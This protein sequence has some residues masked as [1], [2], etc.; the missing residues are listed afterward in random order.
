MTKK[1]ITLTITISD[2]SESFQTVQLNTDASAPIIVQGVEDSS[3]P[4][5]TSVETSQ[6]SLPSSSPPVLS[7]VLSPNLRFLDVNGEWFSLMGYNSGE[8]FSLTFL[9]VVRTEDQPKILS[10]LGN[11]ALGKEVQDLEFDLQ[12]K[13]GKLI[14]VKANLQPE[15]ISGRLS[16]IHVFLT[17]LKQEGEVISG[18][19]IS[20]M[21]LVASKID[22]PIVITDADGAIEL[23][24]ESFTRLT[25]FSIAEVKGR[26]LAYVLQGPGSDPETARRIHQKLR[27]LQTFT[28][29]VLIYQNNK[30]Y[31]LT[32][33]ISPIFNE[34]GEVEKY[35][36]IETD[37]NT[38]KELEIQLRRSE[39]RF[40][41]FL[42]Y[43]PIGAAILNS[44]GKFELL[45]PA[46]CKAV[47]KSS[48]SLLNQPLSALLGNI[49]KNPFLASWQNLLSSVEPHKTKWL[50][51]PENKNVAVSIHRIVGKDNLPRLLIFIENTQPTP[52]TSTPSL[53]ELNFLNALS[54]PAWALDNKGQVR[55]ANSALAN[56]LGY[57]ISEILNKPYHSFIE[58]SSL[59]LQ[60]ER[61]RAAFREES[62]VPQVVSLKTK[63][64]NT[65]SLRADSLLW[66]VSTNEKLL[67]TFWQSDSLPIAKSIENLQTQQDLLQNL[68][69]SQQQVHALRKSVLVVELTPEGIITYANENF[70]EL[71]G[72]TLE[73]LK[74]KP[75]NLLLFPEDAASQEYILFWKKLQGGSFVRG[76]FRRKTKTGKAIWINGAY[77]PII[78]S[79]GNI[80]KILKIATDVTEKN[81]LTRQMQDY[82]EELKA[83]EEELRQNAEE[84]QAINNQMALVQLQLQNQVNALNNSAIV[85][86]TDLQG[87]IIF[88]NDMFTE[89]SKYSKEELLGKN[90]RILKSGHQPQEIFIDL[91]RTISSGKVWKGIIKNRAKDGSYYW[92]ATTIT[93]KLGPDGKPEKYIAIRFDITR[94]K[95]QEIELQNYIEQLKTQEEEIRQNAEELQAINTQLSAAQLHLRNQITALNNSAIV[96]E[97]DLQGNITFV[98]EMFTQ[99]SKYS[100]Q[101]LLGQNHRILK[102][103][104][105]PQ[106]IFIDLWR[107]ISSGKVWK[108]IIKNRAKD[109]SYYWVATTITP[110]L[111]ADGKPTKYIG[112][113]FDITRQKEQENQ[114]E[115]YIFQL[116]SQEEELR[117]NA[118]ELLAIQETLQQ[119]NAELK[120]RMNAIDR[121]NIVIEFDRT[122]HILKLNE[123]AQKLLKRN[124]N[125]CIGMHHSILLFR[126][127]L[128][129]LDYQTFWQRLQG[130]VVISGEFKLKDRENNAVWISGSYAPLMDK[131]NE[132]Y[133]IL[134]IANDTTERNL[135]AKQLEEYLEE[136]RAQ[137]EELRQNAAELESI[138]RE[139]K[140][141]QI[142]LKGQINALN[143]AAI[144]SETDLEGNITFANEM[145]CKVSQYSVEELIGKNHRILKSGLQPQELFEDLWRTISQGKVWKGVIINK[146]KDG[147]FY[148][149]ASTITPEIGED[150]KP[151]KYISVRFEITTQKQQ[152]EQ[153]QQ[154]VDELKAQEEELR[155]NA[156]EMRSIQEALQQANAELDNRMAA[157]DSSSIVLELETNSGRI[158]RSNLNAIQCLGYTEEEFK[159]LT[160]TH[161]LRNNQSITKFNAAWPKLLA[162]I[163]VRE[164]FECSSKNRESKWVSAT[165]SPILNRLK[166]I[167]K[168]LVIAQ[169]ITSQKQINEQ[170]EAFNKAIRE[171]EARFKRL[172]QN[173]PGLLYQFKYAPDGKMGFT[174]ISDKVLELL[175]Y[176]PEEITTL[177]NNLVIQIY[178]EDVESFNL[179]LQE[180]I[181]TLK[182]FNWTGR[183]ITKSGAFQWI[184]AIS[185]PEKLEDESIIWDGI[186]LDATER[187]KAQEEIARGEA[188]LRRTIETAPIGICVTNEYGVFEFVNQAYCH[189]YGYTQE[190]LIGQH[191]TKVVPKD[192][193]QY[194]KDKHTS[195]LNSKEI[196]RGEFEVIT[197]DGR[198]LTILAD[199]AIIQGAD[200][201]PRKVT[202]VIDITE[203]KKFE[204]NLKQLSLVASKTDNA[205]IIA[206]RRGIIEWVNDGFTRIS[207]YTLEEAIGKKPGSF[208]QGPAT[209][210]E[211][212]RRIREGL[213]S[214]QPF[215]AE[216][217]NYHK[218]GRTY[219]INISMTPILDENGEV[220]KFIAIESDIT[221][222]KQTQEELQRLSLVAS[223]TDNI[224]IITNKYGAIEWVNDAFTKLTGYA[225]EEVRGRKPGAFLQGPGTNPDTVRT[226]RNAL[227]NKQ[228]IQVEILNYK[229]S[230]EPYWVNLNI[231]PVF[232]ERGELEKYISIQQ[233]ITER[234]KVE[235]EIELLSL[236]AS[237]TDNAVIITDRF[238]NIEWV[239]DGF[240]RISGYRKEE[241]IGKKPGSFLQGK[242]TDKA[243]VARI[244]ENLRKKISFTEEIL[245][246]TKDGKPYWLQLS[247]TPILNERGELEKFI[248]IESDITE[249]KANEQKILQSKQELEKTLQELQ[250]TQNQLILSE[251]MASLGQLVAGI[252]HEINTP[253]GAVKASSRNI[254]STLPSIIHDFP[255]L[256]SKLPPDKITLL[257]D[258]MNQCVKADTFLTTKEERAKRK[259][260]AKI[261]KE[262]KIKDAE[263][264]AGSLVEIR[265]LENIEK[266][267]PLF[268]GEHAKEILDMAYKLGQMKVNISNINIASEK[269]SKIVYALKNYSHFQ[270]IR[271]KP[272]EVNLAENIENVLV[273]YHNQLKRGIEVVRNFENVPPIYAYADELAQVWTNTIQNAIHAMN[274]QGTLTIDIKDRGDFIAV[275]ITDSGAGIPPEIMDR[276]FEPFFTTKPQGEGSGLGLDITRKII[277]RHH[278]KIEVNSQP[279]KTTFTFLLPKNLQE[280]LAN[281]KK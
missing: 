281:E 74:G 69:D 125:E 233:N 46:F 102:S 253:I 90:H 128:N 122:G 207:G 280:L 149:V 264:I 147:T 2:E 45:N 267:I 133:K 6:K 41:A 238:G 106:E 263:D 23:V 175:G 220:D 278:G 177:G 247:I 105:Q 120:T 11:L 59:K 103:G 224:I 79:D 237:K 37:S 206:N 126:E 191:F 262:A 216:I 20:M 248:A 12:T 241:V 217:L 111:G 172:A 92:V 273:L 112:I 259:E 29:E 212:V 129:S 146:K 28:E 80:Q 4:I 174:Y 214:K 245:N 117:Q 277:D 208:L 16:A 258:M 94:Q 39:E 65:I 96:S 113:R 240:E 110:F 72:Y 232:N 77:T 271:D 5:A 266:Y 164:E 55:F 260:I 24:N 118:E 40:H 276:I 265:V 134:L 148:W 61:L 104:H 89:I 54:L 251:K 7:Q 201:R 88:A 228:G 231:S 163:P 76:E 135:M 66:P 97:T 35:I 183:L 152:E 189:I 179:K 144:V 119:T 198:L 243:T 86:E 98:N 160:F 171:S 140:K 156:E 3:R 161:L 85:S 270:V 26:E 188:R 124:S 14:P 43:A 194:W 33:K 142:R 47:G 205:V 42:D 145:F 78:E 71:V 200:G 254:M 211:D 234:K 181:I 138:N 274:G 21:S 136:M 236:V 227:N 25:G 169:D 31:W 130:G 155:Q 99:I 184:D 38:R 9:D 19:G 242:D 115:S 159:E 225:L 223:K 167:E 157:I 30:P 60:E 95:N 168:I 230:G 131:N 121:A 10:H 48:E 13:N 187:I 17:P 63:N 166:Q 204:E 56:L 269:T 193:V 226:I 32:L 203:R 154:L 158:I 36:A 173:I 68:T 62:L 44:E 82:I 256:L 222:A 141:T 272:V 213:A 139:L 165:L 239:N 279:G 58:E 196:V 107:T 190:E 252:A 176:T 209:N 18:G 15:L 182:K 246:Y 87:N 186:M 219:W 132:V 143:N 100:E 101:E 229:K 70:L 1:S 57:T 185:I 22:N 151:Q 27:S 93:P 34:S 170:I 51:Q 162:G 127:Q 257:E 108:G 221:Y 215:T 192:G 49:E 67:L 64:N 261:L 83:Q 123:N 75:H 250:M 8:L 195:F 268:Q 218:S 210:P 81:E 50:I 202:Y 109:G 235:Q 116:K 178:P 199:A 244:A 91:W 255:T 114:L 150:G 180:S 52:T 275:S 153:L 53:P 137:E 84:L 73:E 249:R 197:K